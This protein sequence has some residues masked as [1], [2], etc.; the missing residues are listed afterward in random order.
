ISGASISYYDGMDD[1]TLESLAFYPNDDS[2]YKYMYFKPVD[3]LK[4]AT[5]PARIFSETLYDVVRATGK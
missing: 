5:L 4:L 2:Q 1:V 3:R